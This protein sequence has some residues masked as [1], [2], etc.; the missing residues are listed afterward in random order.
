[1][2]YEE[3]IRIPLSTGESIDGVLAYPEKIIEKKAVLL[4]S[5]H[6]H[7]AG[8]MDNNVIKGIYS[9]LSAQGLPVLRFNYRG[10]G[11]SSINLPESLSLFDYW[12]DVEENKKY[13]KA[14]EDTATCVTYLTGIVPELKITMIGYS[15]GAIMAMLTGRENKDVESI[16]GIA[17]PL[18]EYDFSS[19]K[20]CNKAVYLIG[21][22]GDF[23]YDEEKFL[24]L[25]DD[26]QALRGYTF[27]DDCDHFFRKREKEL[28][29]RVEHF[30]VSE[31]IKHR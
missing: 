9:H 30:M 4:C 27:F 26:L 16:V 22:S 6:P 20:D 7:F 14:L 11:K 15:F 28:A 8:N 31:K 29:E 18:T 3:K 2:L 1:M 23:V 21:S 13:T 19:L 5:P 17:P 24:A 25:C 10:V 12:E